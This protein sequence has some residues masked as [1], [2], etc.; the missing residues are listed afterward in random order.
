MKTLLFAIASLILSAQFSMADEF[1]NS[2]SA[3]LVSDVSSVKPGETFSVG[4][5]FEIKPDW[6]IYWKNPGDSGLPTSIKLDL[7]EE[8]KSGEIHWPLPTTFIS[9]EVN[10]NY[11]YE[12]TLLLWTTVKAPEN[13]STIM[14]L[15]IKGKA[16]WVSC[17]EICIQG[18][19]ELNLKLNSIYKFNK[20]EKNLFS[21]WSKNLPL[22]SS[23]Q[24]AFFKY[25][26]DQKTAEDKTKH[27]ITIDWNSDV[28]DI[29]FFPNPEDA[30]NIE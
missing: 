24:G 7:P 3:K 21:S 1:T 25:K 2:V 14:P 13:L 17:R 10:I 8:F 11:G 27:V 30:L 20:N 18:E 28:E 23:K 5:L 29:E 16:N 19:S 15:S 4:V 26:I 12:K 22:E 6:H 9:G